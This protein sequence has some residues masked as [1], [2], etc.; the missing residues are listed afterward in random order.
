ML[1]N[2][3]SLCPGSSRV[4]PLLSPQL[5]RRESGAASI[6]PCPVLCRTCANSAPPDST[7]PWNVLRPGGWKRRSCRPV[8]T[9]K[10]DPAVPGSW[11]GCCGRRPVPAAGIYARRRPS[12]HEDARAGHRCP[13]R[14]PGPA[15]CRRG[16]PLYRR[17]RALPQIRGQF[18]P[19]ARG[20]APARR[21][22]LRK[23][24]DGRA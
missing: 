11:P 7:L 9:V 23:G 3:V 18:C 19:V 10:A 21:V 14:I 2:A 6:G 12:R 1:Q 16:G 24:P 20:R 13:G 8:F 22:L 4:I 17:G 5:L 15:V